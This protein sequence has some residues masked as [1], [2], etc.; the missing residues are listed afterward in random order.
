VNHFILP[1]LHS[2]AHRSCVA[3][4]TDAFDA[5]LAASE[6]ANLR[7]FLD[8]W[9]SKQ[10]DARPPLRAAIDPTEIPTLLPN[11]LLIDVIGDP[12]YDFLYRLLGTSI[13]AV[14]GIDYTGS[15]LSQ[16]VPRTD[17]YHLI[18]EHHLKAAAGAIELRHDSL[19]WNR[20]NSRNHVDY[21]ILL[22]PLRRNSDSIDV[23]LGYIHYI[24][25]DGPR[26]WSSL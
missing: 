21:L 14:D 8:Y 6:H 10:T 18:W 2:A 24:M 7:A 26:S 13:V 22:L 25:D 11:L 19:R 5:A 9:Q 20:D 15:T 1:T 23:L 4:G 3:F 12:A 16:M 17:A